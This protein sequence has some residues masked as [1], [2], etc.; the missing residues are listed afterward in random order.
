MNDPVA[1]SVR[2][3]LDGHIV[4]D[5]RLATSGHFPCIDVL[6][7]VSRTTRA[8]TDGPQRTAAS[9]LRQLLAA[10]R[11]AKDLVEIGAYVAGSNPLVDRALQA[12][13]SI[14]TFLRQ[15]LDD[16][17]DLGQSWSALHQLAGAL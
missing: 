7:S 12:S 8:L 15:D 11:D 16:I 4:L 5:R 3:I 2:S 10:R 13:G 14:D 1:D 6:E 9:S 17:A